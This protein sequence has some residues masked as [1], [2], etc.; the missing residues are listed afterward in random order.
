M[1]KTA[2]DWLMP[3]I[4]GLTLE[5]SNNRISQRTCELKILELFEQAKQMEK[6]QI[7]NA[8]NEGETNSVDYFNP[9]NI[10]KEEAEQYYNET[11]GK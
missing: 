4:L 11:F 10:T 3:N 6:Q 8:F 1:E 5:L 2:V 7:M 9:E